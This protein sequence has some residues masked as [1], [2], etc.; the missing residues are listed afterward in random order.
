ML[1]SKA[2][3]RTA[4]VDAAAEQRAFAAFL[5]RRRETEPVDWTYV[6]QDFLRVFA[7]DRRR[8]LGVYYTPVEVVRAQVRLA[9]DL[10]ERRLGCPSAYA[11]PRV[12]VV[13]PAA[14]TGAYPL[15]VVADVKARSGLAP[16]ALGQRLRLLEPMVGAAGIA[17]AQVAAALGGGG[18]CAAEDSVDEAHQSVHV[19]ERDAL[20][21]SLRLDA[22]IV[23]CLGNPPYNRHQ[24]ERQPGARAMLNDFFDSGAGLHAKNL[25]NNYVYFW[26]WA[27]AEVFERRPGP[28]I[29]S[30]VTAASYL[31]GPGFAGM[32]RHLRRVLD[33]LWILDL[34]GDHLAARRTHN[35]F[36]IRTPVAIGMG[37]RYS[38][39]AAREPAVVHYARLVGTRADKLASL[40]AVQT[41]A[42]VPW[43]PAAAAEWSAAFVPRAT[44]A[45]A[46]WPRLTELFPW[47]M[48]GAQLKRTWPIAPTA[49]VLHERWAWLLDMPVSG[50]E[51]AT[52]FRETRDRGL[53]STPT[54]LYEPTTRLEPLRGLAPS[55]ACIQPVQYAY[56]S[57]DRHW[58]LP[59]ARLGDFMRPSL[60]RI[61]GPRQ[62]FLTSLLTNVLG[63]GPAA[64]A[65][66]LVPDMDCF[67]GSFG[68]RA[69]IP[70]FCDT[71]G[72]RPN[73]AAGLLDRLADRYGCA[74]RA[75]HVL[76]YCY[77]LLGT[78]GFQARFEEELRTPGPRVPVTRDPALFKRAAALGSRLLTLHTYG[79][80]WALDVESAGRVLDGVAR[81]LAPVGAAYP[82][83]YWY[84]EA[85]QTLTV[86]EG[87]FGPVTPAAW[88]F[89]VSGL[90]VVP[91]WLRRRI[92]PALHKRG[93]SPLD[94]VQ[95]RAWTAALSRELLELLWVVE[96]TLAMEPIQDAVLD[97]IV[98]TASALQVSSR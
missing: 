16:P 39:P 89:S 86:G 87:V 54:D 26:R 14:G 78:R 41:L 91:A 82:R 23:V 21:T 8:A 4:S 93:S 38:A 45:Y 83:A 12:L 97:E 62:I 19:E 30:F 10:L 18:G 7:P 85:R 71:R 22:P 40:E 72:E 64:V 79:Q 43:Q 15:A 70:L 3:Y 28:G 31:R 96:A 75:E 88:T 57:F 80:R 42:D 46:S 74:I 77:A 5:G 50:Y 35:V 2:P 49:A 11:D 24:A 63:P 76:A 52:A 66:A 32:R 65:T 48:S 98:R 44:S 25:Y 92:A 1:S 27:L 33:E 9:A 36:P 37:V 55:A 17:R 34:E 81:S 90:R 20:A 29:V 47:Q 6:Y 73:L 51:R 67:R 61:A 94:A 13:D 60:W 56:R 95:P 58:V 68:A 84:D 69:V 59:D 53:D